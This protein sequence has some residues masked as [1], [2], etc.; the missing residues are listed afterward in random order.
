MA[1]DRIAGPGQRFDYD[2]VDA[3]HFLRRV[4]RVVIIQPHRLSCRER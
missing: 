4:P 3:E 1:W 2:A